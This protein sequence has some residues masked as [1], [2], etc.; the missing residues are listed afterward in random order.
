MAMG[1]SGEIVVSFEAALQGIEWSDGNMRVS[2]W[3]EE[4]MG[5]YRLWF[6]VYAFKNLEAVTIRLL[7]CSGQPPAGVA[8]NP[9]RTG[10]IAQNSVDVKFWF[11]LSKSEFPVVVQIEYRVSWVSFLGPFTVYATLILGAF[12]AFYQGA[13]KYG[14]RVIKGVAPLI[15]PLYFMIMGE[16]VLEHPTRKDIYWLI[17]KER[18]CTASDIRDLLGISMTAASWHLWMLESRGFIQSTRVVGRIVYHS[19]KISGDAAA[20]LYLLRSPTRRKLVK[21]LL[22]NGPAHIRGI[23]RALSLS[24]ETVKRNAD[25]LMRYGVLEERR[26]QDQRLLLVNKEFVDRLMRLGEA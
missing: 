11:P 15:A 10:R 21:Y 23:A 5:S 24:T 8:R 26:M 22:Q 16:E 18:V 1:D 25:I 9:Y 20:S 12:S 7:N 19:P 2:L 4:V 14:E 3:V 6:K 13:K 17:E